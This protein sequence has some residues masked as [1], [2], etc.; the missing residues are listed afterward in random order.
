MELRDVHAE[1]VALFQDSSATVLDECV[2]AR[3]ELVHATAQVVEA[4]VDGGQLVGHGRRIVR[5]GAH[6]GAE[7]RFEGSHLVA[8]AVKVGYGGLFVSA[9][10]TWFA[11]V[12]EGVLAGCLGKQD[13][14]LR[15]KG[16]GGVDAKHVNMRRA[17][18]EL[19]VLPGVST[20]T[21][22]TGTENSGTRRR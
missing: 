4:E 17:L 5:G 7:R 10:V 11:T 13:S 19:F 12:G 6:R 8:Y 22:A 9:R 20:F 1:L 14:A 18:T 15:Q 16:V 21:F 2:E 3:G